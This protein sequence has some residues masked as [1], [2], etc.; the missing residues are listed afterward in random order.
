MTSDYP[1]TIETVVKIDFSFP[2]RF[3]FI[4]LRISEVPSVAAIINVL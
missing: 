4:A 2:F 3:L 1:A